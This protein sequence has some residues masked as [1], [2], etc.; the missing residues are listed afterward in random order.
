MVD[1]GKLIQWIKPLDEKVKGNLQW[2][3]QATDVTQNE[4]PSIIYEGF[5]A[6]RFLSYLH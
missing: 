3:I 2:N 5:L 4:K 6:K 1:L